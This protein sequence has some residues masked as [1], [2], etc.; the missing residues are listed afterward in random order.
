MSSIDAGGYI[1][2]PP[3]GLSIEFY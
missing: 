2:L 1:K 3:I